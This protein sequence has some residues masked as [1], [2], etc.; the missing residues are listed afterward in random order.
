MAL[1][2]QCV[3][4]GYRLVE[5]CLGQ[6]VC[7]KNLSDNITAGLRANN[8]EHNSNHVLFMV[9]MYFIVEYREVESEAESDWV[10]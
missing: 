10:S 3:Q 9:L 1:L 4:L 6:T 7:P 8:R 2:G 5:C